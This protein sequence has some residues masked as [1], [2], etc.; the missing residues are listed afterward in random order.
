MLDFNQ[1]W[2]LCLH[3][4]PDFFSL[5]VFVLTEEDK[6]QLRHWEDGTNSQLPHVFG[7]TVT[8]YVGLCF[9][10]GCIMMGVFMTSFC[11][12]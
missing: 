2:A 12:F 5:V 4:W 3:C 6:N 7:N 8:R 9:K 10:L 1:K 11:T